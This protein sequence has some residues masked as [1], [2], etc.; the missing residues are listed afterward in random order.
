MSVSHASVKLLSHGSPFR[1]I[2]SGTI[3]LGQIGIE[4]SRNEDF[5]EVLVVKHS[6]SGTSPMSE[7]HA[8]LSKTPHV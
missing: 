7:Q 5:T 8:E 6:G 3:D 1:P 4:R 2:S